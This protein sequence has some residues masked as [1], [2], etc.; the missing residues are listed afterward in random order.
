MAR[1]SPLGEA[2]ANAM[3]VENI[4]KA[5]VVAQLERAFGEHSAASDGEKHRVSPDAEDTLSE[6]V[7][8]DANLKTYYFGSSTITIGK[9]KE[10]EERLLPRR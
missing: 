9:I 5:A 6:G 4:D 3:K 10:M 1:C 2:A 8:D 7:S